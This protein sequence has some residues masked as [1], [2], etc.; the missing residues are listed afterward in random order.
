M[1]AVIILSW[2][3]IVMTYLFK[4]QPLILG[5]RSAAPCLFQYYMFFVLLRLKP[6][7]KVLE[8]WIVIFATLYCILWTYGFSQIPNVIFGNFEETGFNESRG[9]FRLF[10]TG[11]DTLIF[12]IYL[13]VN[14]FS[15]QKKKKYLLCAIIFF[16]FLVLQLTRQTIAIGFVISVIYYFRKRIVKAVVTLLIGLLALSFVG[17]IQFSDDSIVGSLINLTHEQAKD[18]ASGDE[19]ARILEYKYFFTEW[20][21]DNIITMLFGTGNPHA[22]SSFGKRYVNV[23]KEQKHMVL[24][25][26]G[27][28]T[29]Y[30]TVG[31]IGML[32][33]LRIYWKGCRQKV[34]DKYTYAK[35]WMYATVLYNLMSG[36]FQSI[37]VIYC[38]CIALYILEISRQESRLTKITQQ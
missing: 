36:A 19:N 12:A 29:M 24:S 31:L 13:F 21:E 38:T 6:S 35:M 11:C 28:P 9:I 3:S 15:L 20:H 7:V 16:V 22:D 10:F 1:K 23:I 27:Y 26:V 4:E 37:N 17:Q 5:F 18:N 25:D 8:Y 2:L 14:K 30:C 32:V 34:L 33:F